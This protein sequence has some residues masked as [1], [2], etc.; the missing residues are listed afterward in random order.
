VHG[1]AGAASRS[2]LRRIVWVVDDS[3][4]DLSL[5]ERALGR[6]FTVRTFVD[7]SAVLEALASASAPDA[8]V[9][10][11]VMPGVT[12]IEVVRFLRA[13]EGRLP[14]VPV[15]LLTAR[16]RPEQV[17][18]GLEAGANDYVAKPYTDQE[19]RA[20][21]AALVRGGELLER[22]VRAEEA[23]RTLLANAPDALLAVDAQGTVTY[24]N[25]EA[26]RMFER[27]AGDL[28]GQSV[29]GLVPDLPFRN[30]SIAPGVALLPLPDVR[31]GERILSP[32]I[33][34]LPTDTAAR[35][36]IALRDVTE[37]RRIE[38]RRTDF[39]S[40]MAHDLRAPLHSMLIRVD[41]MLKG[42]RGPLSSEVLGEL[43]KFDAN[44]R[45]MMKM[46]KDFH[47]LA[48][49]EGAGYKIDREPL[50]LA[51]VVATTAEELRPVAEASRLALAWRAD[52]A[53]CDLRGD[54]NRIAQVLSNLVGNAIKFT[55]AD[56]RID[57]EV[58]R[59]G[60][61]Y[62]VAVR[63]TGPGI[64]AEALPTLFNR[65]T[66]LPDSGRQAA[67]WGLG[68]MIVREIV[69]AH[70]GE[71]GV[72]SDVGAGSTFWFTLPCAQAERRAATL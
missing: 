45:S 46:I 72:R 8:I 27:A 7:G 5:A 22:A 20:R 16:N 44:I 10:D 12:G 61:F 1:I 26:E 19:F 55:P 14:A 56:G 58:R 63:D 49:M 36:T 33:R 69:E 15:L 65:F 47:D 51:A 2:D 13:S 24:A 54:R 52:E 67:G 11:W 39:Y 43:R 32:S 62:E 50:D 68:L 3:P 28:C 6:D 21:V 29:D 35:T 53:R 40:V 57:I 38:A 9:L 59:V 31:L 17:V 41:L 30:V 37:R 48:A 42:R 25:A 64:P 18:E 4:L 23:V 34:V 66:R 60:D 70:G 71:V